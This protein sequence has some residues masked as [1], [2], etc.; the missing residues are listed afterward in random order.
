MG[1]SN[2][3]LSLLAPS[4]NGPNRFA[5]TT[6]SWEVPT[7]YSEPVNTGAGETLEGLMGKL[8][9][10]LKTDPADPAFNLLG[11]GIPLPAAS[12]QDIIQR[13]RQIM[14]NLT[15]FVPNVDSN[16]NPFANR[17]FLLDVNVNPVSPVNYR[18]MLSA[19]V[20]S[21]RPFNVN[22]PFGNG[23][24]DNGNFVVDESG[25]NDLLLHP[26]DG[27]PRAYDHDNDS[28]I[29]GN[30]NAARQLYAR[31]LYV[32]A[33]LATEFVDRDGNGRVTDSGDFPSFPDPTGMVQTGLDARLEFRK[34]VAQ[35]AINVVDFRDPD[36]IMTPFEVDLNPFDGWDV[37]GDLIADEVANGLDPRFYLRIWGTER[38]ELLLT[39]TIAMH[40]RRTQDTMDDP[41]GEFTVMMGG[42]D[43]NFDSKLVPIS[44]AFFELYNPWVAT[45]DPSIPNS[46]QFYPAELYGG[47]A[48][49][50]L[51]LTD[52]DQN[53]VWRMVVLQGKDPFL[54]DE[55]FNPLNDPDAAYADSNPANDPTIF[56]C[57]YFNEPVAAS[58]DAEGINRMLAYFPANTDSLVVGPGRYAV[59][60]SAGVEQGNVY[61]TY[62]G[63]RNGVVE[64]PVDPSQDMLNLDITRRIELDPS[65]NEVRVFDADN[66]STIANNVAVVA[67]HGPLTAAPA[68]RRSLGLSDPP[69]GYTPIFSD[70]PG[71]EELFINPGID[72]DGPYFVNAAG[73]R[74]TA[75]IPADL[76][77]NQAL[78]NQL[79]QDG[80][81]ES[82]FVVLLQRLANPLESFDPQTNPYRTIDSMPVDLFVFN[83]ADNGDS[84]PSDNM[85]YLG[86][87]ERRSSQRVATL[88]Q[89][90]DNGRYRML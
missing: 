75:N 15:G 33:L 4:L 16:G 90:F 11:F 34:V 21:G 81:A 66:A 38:P 45:A 65:D 60:G 67:I 85:N 59:V 84:T 64:D 61:R 88:A 1:N 57:I 41:S 19:D 49:V 71:S 52:P 31:Q 20:R 44:S 6:D 69:Q 17:T 18:G 47:Q 30:G 56:R 58:L 12:P 79:R 23:I 10:I 35:W 74:T 7:Q 13:E 28:V 14:A 37:N 32:L 24:D 39:E 63:R 22:Q 82:V 89:N 76:Q 68:E 50:D 48:G 26:Q 54:Q 78:A 27:N 87:Y 46:N 83:G 73:E 25:E 2:G 77:A 86:T 70:M 9:A 51:A 80:L 40:D 43:V 3:R 62:L 29:A 42:D 5:A 8:Y 36:S 55:I 72:S 53:P